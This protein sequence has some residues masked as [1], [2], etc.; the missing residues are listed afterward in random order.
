MYL[1]SEIGMIS[2]IT[3]VKGLY[4]VFAVEVLQALSSRIRNYHSNMYDK[5]KL[6]NYL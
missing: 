1:N 3:N 2:N 4:I 6:N 5:Q